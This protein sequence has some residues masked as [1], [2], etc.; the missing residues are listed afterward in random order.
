M[1]K[2]KNRARA[3]CRQPPAACGLCCSSSLLSSPFKTFKLQVCSFHF[4]GNTIREDCRIPRTRLTEGPSIFRLLVRRHEYEQ[5]R[6]K[7]GK[8][9]FYYRSSALSLLPPTL[10]LLLALQPS[11]RETG[12]KR[13]TNERAGAAARAREEPSPAFAKERTQNAPVSSFPGVPVCNCVQAFR[14]PDRSPRRYTDQNV[15]NYLQT[16]EGP[17]LNFANKLLIL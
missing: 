10:M 9:F 14:S 2:H 12:I 6:E 8:G 13:Q 7:E 5:K 17:T 15:P 1:Q 3:A 16:P 11:R 4:P